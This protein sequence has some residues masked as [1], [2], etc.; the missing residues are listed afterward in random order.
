MACVNSDGTLVASAKEVLKAI[1]NPVTPEEIAEK[2]K[3]PLFKVRSSLREMAWFG[4]VT[5]ESGKYVSTDKGKSI[6]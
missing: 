5:E 2:I 6:I 4:Y 1:Q 3:Q